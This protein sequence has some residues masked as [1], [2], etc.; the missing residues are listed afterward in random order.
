MKRVMVVQHAAAEGPGLLGEVLQSSGVELRLVRPF[1]GEPVP[2]DL[3]DASGLVVLGGPMGV[4]EADRFPHL[5]GEQALLRAALDA[6]RPILGI[7]L[8]S[9][10][11][12]AALGANVH[13]AGQK[14]LGWHEV[15]LGTE[16]KFDPLFAG[17]P[18]P[19]P[20][21]HWHGDVFDLPDGAVALGRS[22]QTEVQL[23]RAGA[24]A[25]GLLCHLE[26]T[27]PLIRAMADAFPHELEEV[28][29]TRARLDADTARHLT[30]TETI[31]RAVFARWA[32]LL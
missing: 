9:Q 21:L 14:E 6:G 15:E 25:W 12:A 2:N 7:C 20:A 17:E 11:L 28:K 8:G 31:G 16:A 29:L 27:R 4:Y 24:N 23:F 19:F 1:A 32:A 22:A 13:P 18:T 5:R 10:L 30:R 26:A 3:G